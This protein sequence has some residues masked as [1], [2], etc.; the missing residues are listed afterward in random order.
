MD[1]H[2]LH[3]HGHHPPGTGSARDACAGGRPSARVVSPTPGR[4][5]AGAAPTPQCWGRRIRRELP[6]G[7]DTPFSFK[8]MAVP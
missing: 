5:A 4:A 7:L 1:A 2:V 3:I 8:L 6:G